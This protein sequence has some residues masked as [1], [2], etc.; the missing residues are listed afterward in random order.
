MN[1]LYMHSILTMAFTTDGSIIL[2]INENGEYDLFPQCLFGRRASGFP[3]KYCLVNNT[4]IINHASEYE[5][6]MA[7]YFASLKHEAS[8]LNNDV[9]RINRNA[10]LNCGALTKTT[11]GWQRASMVDFCLSGL[12]AFVSMNESRVYQT[13]TTKDG[14]QIFDRAQTRFMVCAKNFF[15]S[16]NG[17]TKILPLFEFK[18]LVA[19]AAA[20]LAPRLLLFASNEEYEL[21]A[22]FSE[23]L[24]VTAPHIVTANNTLPDSKKPS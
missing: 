10:L 8:S 5:E 24:A 16:Q 20:P 17:S 13:T 11:A 15:D 3:Q 21:V 4:I 18:N 22:A 6:A 1:E 12:A 19:D 2:N 7:H 14:Q 23:M 9:F